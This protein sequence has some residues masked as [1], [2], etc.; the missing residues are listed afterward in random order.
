LNGCLAI[1]VAALDAEM[2]SVEHTK[3]AGLQVAGA[4]ATSFYYTLALNRYGDNEPR[5]AE[6][7][8]RQVYR[9][10]GKHLGYGLKFWP[11][12]SRQ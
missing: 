2:R 11:T 9:H 1:Y 8:K 7:L 5:Y 3:M 12:H 6:L 4:V 10:L